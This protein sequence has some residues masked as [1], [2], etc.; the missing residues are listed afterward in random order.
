MN[1]FA[2][3]LDRGRLPALA[4]VRRDLRIPWYRCPI[5]RR[6]LR[7][8]AKASDARGL[9]QAVGHLG[10]WALT[11]LSAYHL[12]T[13]QIWWGFFV[14]LFA[15]GTV[16]A[17]FTAPHHELCHTTVFRTKRL[18]ELFLRVF[19][20]L[21]WLNF[22]V[23]RFSHSYHHRYTLFIEGDREE[24]MPE[25]PSL[26]ALYLLQLFTVN[27]TGG[28]QSRGLVPT[29]DNFVRLACNRLDN[30]F[31]SWGPELYEGHRAEGRKAAKWARLVLVFHAAVIFTAVAVGEPIVAVLVS[32]S[33][34]VANWLRYFVGVPMHCGLRS[35]VA[36]F[37]KCV[38]TITLD[39]LS[40]FLYWHMN[41]H[42]E[43][44]MYAAVPCYNLKRLHR[45][46]A[47]DM[48]APRTLVGAWREM[49]ETWRRQQTE[50]GYAFDTPVPAPSG[51]GGG[52]ADPLAASMGG[53][54]PRA[55]ADNARSAQSRRRSAEASR[56]GVIIS[57]RA[58]T[59]R[60]SP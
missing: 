51:D 29:L 11:G 41:W 60:E 54:A 55:L 59:P 52:E 48:P 19:S 38:R 14:A 39:P 10:L 16:A 5:E 18:N 21:G 56:S 20:L 37:R 26:R 36:D 46:V 43:H 25:T 13:H 57:R 8:L 42:L 58:R 24:V 28:Y 31:N 53:L 27:V 50:P 22:H 34:F 32:G 23:Y 3:G 40:E 2:N 49:R 17:F 15:H 33:V 9:I 35:G 7:E 45:A 4:D 6:T 47:R 12:F 1:P 44:H 30:P